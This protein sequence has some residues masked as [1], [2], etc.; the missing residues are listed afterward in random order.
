LVPAS[1]SQSPAVPIIPD[2]TDVYRRIMGGIDPDLARIPDLSD[3]EAEAMLAQHKGESDE[4]YAARAE[5]YTVA[6]KEYNRQYRD[7]IRGKEREVQ[8]FG[9]SIQR[10]DRNRELGSSLSQIESAISQS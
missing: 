2:G 10:E 5:R 8:A 3:Q 7:Y 6:L 1:S 4:D 9:D